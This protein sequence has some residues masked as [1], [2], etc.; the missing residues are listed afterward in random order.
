MRLFIVFVYYNIHVAISYLWGRFFL[1]TSNDLCWPLG[2][3]CIQKD[4]EIFENIQNDSELLITWLEISNITVIRSKRSFRVRRNE[5]FKNFTKQNFHFRVQTDA[6][7]MIM[8]SQIR[9]FPKIIK[10]DRSNIYFLTNVLSDEIKTN[11]HITEF[12]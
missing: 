11:K 6:I 4:S 12:R 2:K 8:E 5:I 7:M 9:E 1:L 10:N 3:I